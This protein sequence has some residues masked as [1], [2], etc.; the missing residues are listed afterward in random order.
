[1]NKLKEFMTVHT[2]IKKSLIAIV[3]MASVSAISWSIYRPTKENKVEEV[4]QEEVV[5]EEKPQQVTFKVKADENWTSESTPVIVHIKGTK[6]GSKVDFYHAIKASD[7]A[8]E[9]QSK[10]ELTA[11]DYEVEIIS[12]LNK[13]GSTMVV[14]DANDANAEVKVVSKSTLKVEEKTAETIAEPT[15]EIE[16]KKVDADKVTDDM[17]KQIVEETKVA[18]DKGDETLKGED[19]KVVLEKVETNANANPNVSKETVEEAK[20]VK[21]T[22]DTSKEST[23]K[24]VEETKPAPVATKPENK[25]GENKPVNN[26]PAEKPEKKWIPEKGHW[27]NVTEKVWVSK[28]VTIVDEP[29]R[30]ERKFVGSKYIFQ[31]DGFV[32][33]DRNEANKHSIM[34]VKQGKVGN[35]RI[36]PIYETKK[37][38]AKTHQEDQGHYET[39]VTGRKWV[40]DVQGHW[41]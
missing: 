27:E 37:I 4:K 21:Q 35:F 19:G 41:E 5:K 29:A 30:T 1:M 33:T 18:V 28:M 38:P 14:S 31:D 17:V 22:A 6:E 25:Q 40:V 20:E 8:K 3:I 15:K 10:V 36:E 7:D 13:D 12:P 11:G 9:V 26:K 32:T 16:M 34:L 39:K 2:G 23:K 24:T